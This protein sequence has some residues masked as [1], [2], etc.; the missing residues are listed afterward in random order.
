MQGDKYGSISILLP[1]GPQFSQMPF[2]KKIQSFFPVH[3]PG[4]FNQE[5]GVYQCVN[6]CLNLQ[7][8]SINCY[9]FLCQYYSVI[10][11]IAL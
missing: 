9:V 7:L 11:T 2:K 8:Y 4:F 3:T 1:E 10:I 6:L 5:S